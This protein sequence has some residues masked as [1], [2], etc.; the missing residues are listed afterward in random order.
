MIPSG[1]SAASEALGA[2]ADSVPI[3]GKLTIIP[4]NSFVPPIPS[5]LPPYVAMFNPEH[6]QVQSSV[7][8]NTE[9]APVTNADTPNYEGGNTRKLSFELTV[10]GTGASGETREVLA[11]VNALKAIIGFNGQLHE[12]NRLLIVW[13][14]QIFSGVHESISVKYTLFRANGTPLRAVVS[15]SFIEAR[16]SIESLLKLNLASSDLT[17]IRRVR[18]HDRLDLMAYQIYDDSRF[19]IEVADANDLTTFRTLPLGEELV[20]PPTEK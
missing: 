12:T 10:D 18:D 11:D 14:S 9:R 6:W 1:L 13:G 19:Y 4:M 2:V 8:Y 20:F 5:P 16:D 15:L 17:H 7:S 3:P